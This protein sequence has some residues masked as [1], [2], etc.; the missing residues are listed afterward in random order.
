M[1]IVFASN[2]AADFP[3]AK[4]STTAG[5][6]RSTY[7][8]KAFH[9]EGNDV[10]ITTLASTRIPPVAGTVTWIHFQFRK[11]QNVIPSASSADGNMLFDLHSGTGVKILDFDI[12]NGVL[13]CRVFGSSTLTS[14]VTNR[15]DGITLMAIDIKVDLTTDIS[16]EVYKDG[17]LVYNQSQA[18]TSS[19]GNPEFIFWRIWDM[20]GF[21][22]QEEDQYISELIIADESTINMGLSD[23]TPNAAG[24]YSQWVGNH[25]ETGDTDLGTGASV[26]AVSQKLSSALSTFGGPASSALRALVVVNKASTRGG[27]VN[28][29]R[30]FL[31]ISATDY[32]GAA[33]GVGES[34]TEHVT[35]WDVNPNTALDW[36]TTDFA[37][38]EVGIESLA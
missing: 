37:G 26:A 2:D 33:L 3:G 8:D 9:M 14:P 15:L 5:D 28:D 30:N 7:V 24:N 18:W 25:V 10:R 6:F 32:N 12:L 23:M 16:V 17:V 21:T 38:V 22:P 36:D 34:I 1:S 20:R 31:R 19:P 29:L 4:V 11:S 35:V 13:N 27:T